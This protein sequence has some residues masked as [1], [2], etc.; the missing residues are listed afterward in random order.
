MHHDLVEKTLGVTLLEQNLDSTDS[1]Y[2]KHLRLS[3][4]ARHNDI[5]KRAK[6]TA[7]APPANA[8]ARREGKKHS[9]KRRRGQ[10]RTAR[11]RRDGGGPQSG[12]EPRSTEY[13]DANHRAHKS[14]EQNTT[15]QNMT[16]MHTRL[17]RKIASRSF[18]L[19]V[20][21]FSRS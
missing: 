8:V 18:F 12:T 21:I 13:K 20:W 16:P 1:A 9:L 3:A 5:G 14:E 10:L 17:Q 6:D 19:R 15:E 2:A 11:P 7:R 4:T